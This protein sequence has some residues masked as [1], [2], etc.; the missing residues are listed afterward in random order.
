[1]GLKLF[2]KNIY[3]VY[4]HH[5]MEIEY[6]DVEGHSNNAQYKLRPIDSSRILEELQP[7]GT[8][9]TISN[10]KKLL[11]KNSGLCEG[12]IFGEMGGC[13]VGTIW[14]MYK[15]ANDLEYRIRDIDAYIFDVFVNDRYRGKGYAG[16]MIR[17]LI[18]YLHEKGI[19]TARLAVAKTNKSAIIA[20]EKTGFTSVAD[21]KFARILKVNIPYHR[22]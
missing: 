18:D 19:D 5:I 20:Y 16:E 10:L 2:G 11:L 4:E 15:G 14:V 8:T 13:S 9:V 7:V 6:K 3:Q 12:F 17:Q 21:K 1:M 22:L